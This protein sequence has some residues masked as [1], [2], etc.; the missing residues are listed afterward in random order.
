MIILKDRN[1]LY[2][3]LNK[4]MGK[5]KILPQNLINLIAAG[6]V[7]ERPASAL[8]ELLENSVDA[9]STQIIV[10]L[11]DYGNK[12]IQVK[13]NGIGMNKDDAILAFVQHATSKIN[14]EEDL[15]KILTL[16]FRGEALAS[17][18]SVAENILLQTK[19]ENGKPVRILIEPHKITEQPSTQTEKG[20]TIS[21][22][23]IF[24]NVPARKKFLKSTATELKYLINTFIDIALVNT[25][26]HFELYHNG[27]LIHKL[28]ETNNIKDRI[29]EIWGKSVAKDLYDENVFES[30]LCKIQFVLGSPEI[31]R[32]TAQLQ[33]TYVNDR[34]IGSKVLSSAVQEAYK[35]FIHRDLKPVYFIFIHIDPSIV[36]VNIH[37]RKLE[38]KFENSQEMFRIIYTNVRKILENKTKSLVTETLNTNTDNVFT[39]NHTSVIPNFVQGDSNDKSFTKSSF[40]DTN[41]RQQRVQQALSFTEA[42]ARDQVTDLR[43]QAS[44][45]KLQE[46]QSDTLNLSTS[47]NVFQLFNTYILVENIDNLVIIDQ[48]AAAEKIAFEKLV[49]NLGHV[50]TKALLVPEILE[51]SNTDK[52]IILSKKDELKKI[53]IIIEDFGS[54]SIQ[55]VEIPEVLERLNVSDY[56][57]KILKPDEDLI[58]N[59]ESFTTFNELTLTP[60][61]YLLLATTACHGSIR[62]GQK[63]NEAEM[64]NIMNE[65]NKLK[66]PYNCPH[67]RPTLWQLSRYEIE[68]NFR[69]KI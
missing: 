45:F 4:F 41:P 22:N 20:T 9:K 11:E 67:G 28:T 29:F 52:E 58:S 62:A 39:N 30:S 50:Q 1:T 48:H 34:F 55:V 63:L 46:D 36:D 35:G 44:D 33:Y 12:L 26:I 51:I 2:I 16:G 5:I 14:T 61:M 32:K 3:L 43:L 13:D 64:K 42:L 24:S 21:I 27:K 53:G 6:E 38:I 15:H 8:K 18:S 49:S 69:R 7:V 57:Q 37:P 31:A 10:N 56:M 65:L 25:H 19:L 40:R 17:I 60:E 66:N 68:K 59:F 23:N 54:N 47:S